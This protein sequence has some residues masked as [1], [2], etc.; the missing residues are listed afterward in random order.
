MKEFISLREFL[1]LESK[2]Y[3][4]SVH[5]QNCMLAIYKRRNF[6]DKYIW[7][8]CFAQDFVNRYDI[9]KESWEKYGEAGPPIGSIVETLVSGYGGYSGQIRIFEGINKEDDRLFVI[10]RPE[11]NGYDKEIYLVERKTWWTEI[12]VIENSN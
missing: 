7:A 1:L 10:S 2:T 11:G 4:R 3:K 12:M 9:A 5:H 8:E 6:N